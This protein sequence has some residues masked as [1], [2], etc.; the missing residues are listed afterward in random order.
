MKKI[1]FI[2]MLVVS[3][4]SARQVFPETDKVISVKANSYNILNID[5]NTNENTLRNSREEI[6]LFE[7]DFE[8]DLWNSDEGWTL[9]ES[10]YYS[11]THSYVSPND[12]S[13]LGST[14]NLVSDIVTLPLLGDG[15]VMQFDF[16]VKGDTPDTDGDDDGFLEDYYQL[17]IMDL[18]AL[19]WHASFNVPD[20]PNN[21]GASYWCADESVGSSGGYLDEW[22]QYLDTPTIFVDAGDQLNAQIRFEIEDEAGADGAIAGSCT[23]GWDSANIRISADGGETWELLVDPNNPYDFD[24]GY[25]WIYN[26]PEYE[27]GGSLNQVAPG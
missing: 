16:W 26:D 4:L 17:S 24:C 15:E 21:E 18:N 5:N 7:W 22:M 1:I 9:T 27:T 12:A 23:D 6:T 2:S 20:D 25:G 14:W 13:T 11:E 8:G 10:D 3:L 19:A